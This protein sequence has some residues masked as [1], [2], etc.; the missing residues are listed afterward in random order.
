[1]PDYDAIL[2]AAGAPNGD[3]DKILKD[4][5]LRNRVFDL[6]VEQHAAEALSTHFHE[7][8]LQALRIRIG[9]EVSK[10]KFRVTWGIM[11]SDRGLSEGQTIVAKSFIG[12]SQTH[13]EVFYFKPRTIEEARAIKYRGQPVPGDILYLY[14]QYLSAPNAAW[15][16]EERQQEIYKAEKAAKDQGVLKGDLAV[17]VAAQSGKP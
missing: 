10:P 14:S 12:D 13:D 6:L 7:M 16:A 8:E 4:S 1:M 9:A 2:A 5:L 11:P 15:L 17:A 3:V